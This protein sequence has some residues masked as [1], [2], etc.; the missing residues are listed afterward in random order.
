MNPNRFLCIVELL[1]RLNAKEAGDSCFPS[2]RGGN[3][4]TTSEPEPLPNQEE[5]EV[6]KGS[7][8]V[9]GGR[10]IEQDA[11]R[12]GDY[13]LRSGGPSDRKGAAVN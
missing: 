7:I 12:R 2:G 4:D 10:T 13:N 6:A 3:P 1:R 9:E 5:G 8:D 11:D